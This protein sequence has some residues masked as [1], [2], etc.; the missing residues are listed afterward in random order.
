MGLIHYELANKIYLDP[1]LDSS[2]KDSTEYQITNSMIK[3]TYYSYSIVETDG[4]SINS[5]ITKFAIGVIRDGI[6]GN[7][8]M[9][10]IEKTR[11]T[12]IKSDIFFEVDNRLDYTNILKSVKDYELSPTM[13]KL[14]Y[15]YKEGFPIMPDGNFPIYYKK[16]D[17][18]KVIIA[19]IRHEVEPD[20]FVYM[21]ETNVG[22]VH[23]YIKGD[24][25]I[26]DPTYSVTTWCNYH[27]KNMLPGEYN[28]HCKMVDTKY[29]RLVSE[30]RITQSDIDF[31]HEIPDE[32][33]MKLNNIHIGTD[34]GSC[35]FSIREPLNDGSLFR[36]SELRNIW[37]MID[38]NEFHCCVDEK[39]G[40]FS[41]SGFG[42]GDYTAYI[43][44]DE[45]GKIYSVKIDYMHSN[46]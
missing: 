24:C 40:V 22:K 27:L 38:Q 5:R 25:Y 1:Q 3:G 39:L 33:Y 43:A 28:C 11:S 44:K 19:E 31:D 35:G 16:N 20:E 9:D 15:F 14:D 45:T 12:F 10:D 4:S 41:N 21:K 29:G 36:K 6:S 34:S 7:D 32:S 13:I 37:R 8:F 2:D 46:N 30:L 26:S 18:G 17:E 23:V 42:D